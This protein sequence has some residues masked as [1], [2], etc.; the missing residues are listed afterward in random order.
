M[1]TSSPVLRVRRTVVG[2]RDRVTQRQRDLQ[3]KKRR[4]AQLKSAVPPPDCPPGWRIAPPDFVGVGVQKAGTSW[5]HLLITAHPEVLARMPKELHFFQHHWNDGDDDGY[6][7]EYA[8]YF[9]RPNG[10]KAGEW[11][12]RYAMDAWTPPMLARAAP[13]ARLL[14]MLRDPV[15]RFRSG[16]TH[17]KARHRE[18]HPRVLVEAI[19][20]GRYSSHLERLVRSFPREQVLVLQYERCVR[21]P[22]AEL[23]RTYAFLGLRDTAFVPGGVRR[24]VFQ[25]TIV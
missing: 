8:R 3:A 18:M 24:P 2:W 19:E 9:A 14:V 21:D 1:I 12:P 22:E 15:E 25:T 16:L 11:T 23:A 10:L 20:R 17:Y 7:D 4:Q 13:D 5:W 6:I